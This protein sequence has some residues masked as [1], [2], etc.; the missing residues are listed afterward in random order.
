MTRWALLAVLLAAAGAARSEGPWSGQS[1]DAE[2][3][4]QDGGNAIRDESAA[5]EVTPRLEFR[6]DAA[7]GV[8][9][10]IDWRRFISSFSTE[11]GFKVDGG[12]FTWLK[13]KVDDS[14]KVTVSPSA[15]DTAR[16]IAALEGGDSVLVDVTPYSEAPVTVTFELAG[17]G[18][19]LARLRE[20]CR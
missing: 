9:A 12:K 19:A 4:Y 20:R 13:W 17:L 6:C 10:R 11:V 1:G 18:E 16:L 15:A 8:V 7:G 5:N 2:A 3:I 14:E